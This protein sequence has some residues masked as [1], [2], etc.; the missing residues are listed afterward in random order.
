MGRDVRH[1]PGPD[2]VG[3][4]RLELALHDVRRDRVRVIRI[5]RAPKAPFLPRDDALFAH[6]PLD[7]LLADADALPAKGPVNA[8]AAVP[9]A[10]LR[11]RRRDLD[12]ELR[13]RLRPLAARPLLPGVV[14]AAGDLEHLAQNGDRV[15]RL[16]RVDEL[17]HHPFSFAKKAAAFFNISRSISSRLTRLRSS[18][19]SSRSPL[20]QRLRR[21]LA[22]VHIRALHPLTQRGLGQIQVVRHLRDAPVA[23]PAETHRFGLELR[24][25]LPSLPS[26]LL[27]RHRTLLAHLRACWGVRGS[28]G[29]SFPW[30]LYRAP[31][32]FGGVPVE[33]LPDE[34]VVAGAHRLSKPRLNKHG[35][36]TFTSSRTSFEERSSSGGASAW[37][38]PRRLAM[39]PP[40]SPEA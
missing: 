37:V 10:A 2:L 1:V 16:L 26:C 40:A 18:R 31:Q 39:Q 21:T 30:R 32:H 20:R 3:R 34:P 22:G 38:R 6:Q 14:A 25:E 7:P 8:R 23:S 5:G 17:E 24:G 27:L 28:G 33:Y 4:A 12:G 13:V 9:L 35:L 29:G 19:S 15:V 11:V 36:F